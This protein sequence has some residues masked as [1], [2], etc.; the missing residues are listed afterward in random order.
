MSAPAL[1]W[2]PFPD[3][4]SAEAAA[5]ALLE[6][7]LVACANLLPAMTSLYIWN[8]ERDRAEET[9]ALF[10]T[11]TAVLGA[12][13]ARLA[14]LHPYDDPAILGWRCDAAAPGTAAWLGALHGAV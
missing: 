9:G 3:A 12:A 2:C 4:G 6:E 13:I 5:N 7:R 10:K 1:I 8:G 14:A 11:N